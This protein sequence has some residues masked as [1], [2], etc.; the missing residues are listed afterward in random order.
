[1][2]EDKSNAEKA[3]TNI[4]RASTGTV[5]VQWDIEEDSVAAK[6]SDCVVQAERGNAEDLFNNYEHMEDVQEFTQSLLKSHMKQPM[7]KQQQQQQ[8]QQQSNTQ[9]L[10]QQS[11]GTVRVLVVDL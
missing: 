1:M 4:G 11:N 6:E 2:E 3:T 7:A 8:Q 5:L 9:S 10:M